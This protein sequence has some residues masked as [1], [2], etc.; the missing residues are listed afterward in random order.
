M[1]SA[2]RVVSQLKDLDD[3]TS[4]LTADNDGKAL[5]Y[6]HDTTAF[7]MGAVGDA[8][9]GV[10]VLDY[11]TG[12]GTT[13]DGAAIAT[14][15]A[16]GSHIYFPAATYKISTGITLSDSNKALIFERGAILKRGANSITVLTVTGS[17]NTITGAEINGD[18]TT[19]GSGIFVTG[20]RNSIRNCIIHDIAGATSLGIGLDGQATTC[21][22]NEVAGCILYTL[23]GIGIAQNKATDSRIHDNAVIG[24]AL[25]GIT[26]DNQAHRS[27]VSGNKLSGCCTAGGVASIGI[28]YSDLCT[29][30]GN[31]I[32]GSS[33]SGIKTQNNLGE[34]NY[35]TVTG[36]VIVDSTGY[37]IWLYANGANDSSYW[38]ITG[39]VLRNNSDGAI[40]IDAGC[41]YAQLSGNNLTGGSLT[42]GGTGTVLLT[43]D[44]ATLLATGARAGST[45]QAQSFGATG[46]KADV[47]AESTS[48]AG[49][50]I[51][52]VLIKD[53]LVDGVDVS[54]AATEYS[55]M[56]YNS[57]NLTIGN[58]SWTAV[59]L[60][61]ER[62]DNGAMHSTSTNNTRLTNTTGATRRFIISG[63]VEFTANA[64][65]RRYIRVYA[66]GTTVVAHSGPFPPDASLSTRLNICGIVELANNGYVELQ[67]F[68]DSGGD[69]AAL[70]VSAFSPQ[71]GMALL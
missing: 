60:D 20:A 18:S 8:A 3:V 38:T 53:G 22:N 45:S 17:Y 50:T 40:K 36:N 5:V 41:N 68:Q 46:I 62:F 58:N 54:A 16:A 47:I 69:L 6:D 49:V 31:V 70:A 19:A 66:N 10:N 55:V 11:A 32:A 9:L 34:S 52:S 42:D 2:I 44:S 14:A 7:A 26:I 67:V 63:N 35:N 59:T 39:N 27:M 57:G 29:I 56:A 28:D 12:D 37:G 30:T 13:D 24:A 64:N 4:L 23:G 71:F 48:A 33:L 21:A 51:D 43:D 65:G 1:P 15:I 61:S 25:E